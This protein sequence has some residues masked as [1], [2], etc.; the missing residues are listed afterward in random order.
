MAELDPSNAGVL[1]VHINGSGGGER[2]VDPE[3]IS[4]RLTRGDEG[5]TIM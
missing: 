3:E 5:C 2:T 4:R 1:I